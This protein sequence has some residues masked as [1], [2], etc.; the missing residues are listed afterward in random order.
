[1]SATV[2]PLVFHGQTGL[3]LRLPDGA[4]A[5]IALHGA[6]VL[7]WQAH[8]RIERLYLSPKAVFDGKAAIRGGIPVCFPQFNQRVIAERT[9]PKHGFART[10]AWRVGAAQCGP[11][12][13]TQS[14]MLNQDDLPANL[15]QAWPFRFEAKLEVQLQ[16]R[17]LSVRFSVHNTG[18]QAL[19]FALAL[20]T[21]FRLDD[22]AATRLDGLQACT[23]WDAVTHLSSPKQL[24]QQQEAQLG[25]G[26]ETDRVYHA[27]PGRLKIQQTGSALSVEQSAGFTE[28]VVWTPGE[29]LCSQLAD[30]PEDGY[31]HVLCVEAARI[32][33][34]LSL[35]PGEHWQGSQT[36]SC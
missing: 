17:T 16:S 5:L 27:P 21:Y 10:L 8:D 26:G 35:A 13:V 4:R 18:P 1:M 6:Q 11:E 31:R 29:R 25:F 33:E 34:P 3:E 22:I 2:T 7:S 30:M 32:N 19:P 20:H 36:L 12:Q 14:L 15:Q 23:F 9:L 24:Q 28:T